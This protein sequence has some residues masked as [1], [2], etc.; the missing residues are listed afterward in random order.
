MGDMGDIV[1]SEEYCGWLGPPPP[2]P[3]RSVN[4]AVAMI[5]LQGKTSLG[6]KFE[7]MSII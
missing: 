7:E 5:R 6:F 3:T 1:L 4:D 2:P